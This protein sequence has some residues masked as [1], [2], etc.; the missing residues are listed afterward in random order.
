MNAAVARAELRELC[1]RLGHEPAR[2]SRIIIEPD[3]IT[4][5]YTHP[6]TEAEQ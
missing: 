2:V 4:V 3:V 5:E 6:V 1:E